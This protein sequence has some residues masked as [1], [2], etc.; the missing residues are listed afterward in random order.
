MSS[1]VLSSHK[2]SKKKIAW[3]RFILPQILTYITGNVRYLPKNIEWS[4][5]L[6]TH[7]IFRVYE[8]IFWRKGNPNNGDNMIRCEWAVSSNGGLVKFYTF[9]AV[10][11]HVEGLIRGLLKFEKWMPFKIIFPELAGIGGL[12][13]SFSRPF[14]FA[15][16]FDQALGQSTSVGV[17]T[18]SITSLSVSGTDRYMTHGTSIEL[19][20]NTVSS[21][22]YD[23][24]AGGGPQ[25]FTQ[26]GNFVDVT[27]G[28]FRNYIHRLVAPTVGTG[29]RLIMTIS[30]TS[31]T[32]MGAV[33]YTGVDQTTP[34]ADSTDGVD[35]SSGA[36]ITNTSNLDGSWQAGMIWA[37][38]INS[39][40]GGVN[41][42]DI[43]NA[44]DIGYLLDSNA[45]VSSGNT[46]TFTYT[47]TGVVAES[48]YN[49][50]MLR[51]TASAAAATTPLPTLLLMNVGQ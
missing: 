13:N 28:N 24:G 36:A 16:A 5:A 51:P 33:H 20:T 11:A 17:G 31:N 7:N 39:L 45:T 48:G 50:Y 35:P 9:E 44:A 18:N 1:S 15:I 38:F 14:L 30:G 4:S 19:T 32:N 46:N 12:S 21:V 43:Q 47:W 2:K 41:R 3:Y 29:R 26:I 49:T 25:S 27:S 6:W 8:L 23:D 34:T 22:V 42:Q 40:S 37:I 10:I